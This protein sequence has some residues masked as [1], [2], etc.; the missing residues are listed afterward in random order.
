MVEDKE[1]CERGAKAVGKEEAK[2][3]QSGRGF[4]EI[5]CLQSKEMDLKQRQIST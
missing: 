1:E 5:L 3:G 2:A 4:D